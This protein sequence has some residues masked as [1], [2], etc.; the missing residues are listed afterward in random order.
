MPGIF[1]GFIASLISVPLLGY[2]AV[3]VISKQITGNHKQAVN[4]AIDFSTFLLVLSVHFLV[5]TIWE[6][7]FLW[8][9]GRAHV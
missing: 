2:L 7:S 6:K 1:S 8:Q 9:I 4:L 5:I 3:F